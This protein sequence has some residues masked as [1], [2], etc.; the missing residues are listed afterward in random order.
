MGQA[1]HR[2][3]CAAFRPW[4][5]PPCSGVFAAYHLLRRPNRA[6]THAALLGLFAAVLVNAVATNGIKIMV[7]GLQG[8][9]EFRV[10]QCGGPHRHQDHGARRTLNTARAAPREL[11]R[12]LQA[13]QFQQSCRCCTSGG[14]WHFV[15]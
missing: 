8:G 2:M 5:V 14:T 9:W 1:Q 6:D 13:L 4:C 7:R 11:Q 15:V 3:L 10:C 12:H